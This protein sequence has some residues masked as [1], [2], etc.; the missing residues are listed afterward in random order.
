[1]VERQRFC[2]V[3]FR[4]R[5]Q[6]MADLY[7]TER[8]GLVIFWDGWNYL[9]SY[10]GFIRGFYRA[11]LK[12]P[13][14]QPDNSWNVTRASLRCSLGENVFFCLP[15]SN[16]YCKHQAPLRVWDEISKR[17]GEGYFPQNFSGFTPQKTN[18]FPLKS[19]Y[20]SRE[21]I[22]QPWTF[23]GHVRFQGL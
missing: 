8:L 7:T 1:M 3:I 5:I 10:T 2:H 13:I 20:F 9:P 14:H 12:I 6:L 19:D 18:M 21:H 16:L 11:M 22:F 23:R 15:Q 4:C 17:V